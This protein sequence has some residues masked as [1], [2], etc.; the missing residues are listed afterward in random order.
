MESW[1]FA[2]ENRIISTFQEDIRLGH[3]RCSPVPEDIFPAAL[4]LI[5]LVAE[6]P[7]GTLD[8]LHLAIARA[9]SAETVVTA[10]QVMI[11]AG[12]ALGLSVARFD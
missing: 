8:A 1:I 6:T 5:S 12:R 3:L 10:D 2:L 7:L 11:R 9:L 4:N